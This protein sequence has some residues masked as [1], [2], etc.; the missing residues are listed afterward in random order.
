VSDVSEPAAGGPKFFFQQVPYPAGEEDR[1][2]RERLTGGPVEAVRDGFLQLTSGPGLGISVNNGSRPA[3]F[4]G[5]L[6]QPRP[7]FAL[8]ALFALW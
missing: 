8:C 7:H 4:R 5:G 3:M 1:R 2:M 6:T